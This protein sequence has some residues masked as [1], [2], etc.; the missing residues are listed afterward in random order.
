MKFLK[1]MAWTG[2]AEGIFTTENGENYSISVQRDGLFHIKKNLKFINHTSE[3]LAGAKE[4]CQKIEDNTLSY[5][6][7]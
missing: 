7:I 5:E 6:F 3:T 4:I 2:I 1:W